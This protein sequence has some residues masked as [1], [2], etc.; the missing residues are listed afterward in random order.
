[1]K[2]DIFPRTHNDF[3]ARLALKKRAERRGPP[4]FLALM[5]E[6]HWFHRFH[7]WHEVDGGSWLPL[8]EG[9]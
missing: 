3:V 4:H 7:V 9:E 8:G 5:R 6:T 1:M 2:L